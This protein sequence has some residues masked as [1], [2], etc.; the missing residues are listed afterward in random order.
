MRWGLLVVVAATVTVARADAIDDLVAK[1][2]ELAK[3]REYSQAIAAFKEADRGRPT[4]ANACRIGL[5]Y[6]RR[7]LWSQAE[8][9]FA[10]CRERASA[11]DPAPDWAGE[12]ET[13]LAQKIESAS[14]PAITIAVTPTNAR[15]R[16]LTFPQ[17]EDFTARTIHLSAGTYV[18]EV[19]TPEYV[20]ATREIVVADQPQRVEIALE[21]I[22]KPIPPP[23]PP[24]PRVAASNAPLVMIGIGGAIGLAAIAVDVFPV[25]TA[26]RELLDARN[27]EQYADRVDRYERWRAIDIG[28]TALAVATTSVGVWWWR[29]D[30]SRA[31]VTAQLR[32]SGATIGMEWSLR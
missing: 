32:P 25:R 4:A 24:P 30:L 9:F 29:H 31:R 8:V 28:L 7:E 16:I 21:P 26:R 5:A 1:G 13:A 2:E 18:L 15:I 27:P 23:P 10:R 20:K 14:V 22:A 3:R 11:T 17:D 19:E 6:T 12:A